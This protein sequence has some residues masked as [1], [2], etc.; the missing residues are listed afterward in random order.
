[1]NQ[2]EKTERFR[3]KFIAENPLWYSGIL[4][5][6]INGFFLLSSTAF[7][8]Y[9]INDLRSIEL[10]AIPIILI[11]GNLSVYLI[12]RY[13][14][15]MKFRGIKDQTYGQHTLIHHRFYTNDHYQV[16]KNEKS[17]SFLFPPI[18]VILFCLIILPLLYLLFNLF[19]PH[20]LLYLSLGMSSSYFILYEIVHYASHLPLGHWALRFG[21]FRRMRQHH[22]DHHNPRL[23]D[24]YNFNIVFPLFDH[25]FGTKK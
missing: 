7:F 21:H 15:H 20:N 5:Y 6:I 12:H 9:Q 22:L 8:F 16:A 24:K 13:P 2:K 17:H 25:V 10:L 4:H 3:K 11:A 19:L 23:M 14:L 18:V 1:M